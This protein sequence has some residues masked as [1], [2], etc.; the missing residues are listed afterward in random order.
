MV[1]AKYLEFCTFYDAFV[2][3]SLSCRA[4]NEYAAYCMAIRTLMIIIEYMFS[5][6]IRGVTADT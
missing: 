5:G 6:N 3:L 2:V 1:L 4:E